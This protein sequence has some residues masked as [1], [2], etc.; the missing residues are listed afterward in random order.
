MFGLMLSVTLMVA[1]VSAYRR[2]VVHHKM[3]VFANRLIDVLR[4]ARTEAVL[5]GGNVSLC[6]VGVGQSCGNN[7]RLGQLLY[8]KGGHVLR[9]YDRFPS[10]LR[11]YWRSRLGLNAFIR[12]DA[13]GFTLGQQGS[14]WICPLQYSSKFRVAQIILLATGMVHVVWHSRCIAAGTKLNPT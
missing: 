13:N 10:D 4:Y 1:G 14:F 2:F 3:V 9:V 11:L 12:W 5:L 8:L 6:P 7:W